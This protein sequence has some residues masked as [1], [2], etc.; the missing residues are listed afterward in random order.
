MS[1]RLRLLFLGL[2]MLGIAVCVLEVVQ[3]G[4]E[5][6]F[7]DAC[8]DA[9]GAV[10]YTAMTCDQGPG[11]PTVSVIHLPYRSWVLGWC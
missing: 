3:Y 10:D 4:R 6:M 2:A 1:A 7:V 9:G 11:P 5:W 8:L